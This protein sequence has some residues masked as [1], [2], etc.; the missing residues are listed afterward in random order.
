MRLAC[1]VK[2][3]LSIL[4]GGQEILDTPCLFP[5]KNCFLQIGSGVVERLRISGKPL[6]QLVRCPPSFALEPLCFRIQIGLLNRTG[7]RS[8]ARQSTMQFSV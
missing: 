7:Q 2:P 1:I 5:G 4:D 3:L 8:F 6:T